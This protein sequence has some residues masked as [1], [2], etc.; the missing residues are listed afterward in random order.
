MIE[1]FVF[2][3]NKVAAG[4]SADGSFI[5][6][7]P[8]PYGDKSFPVFHDGIAAPFPHIP[9]HVIPTQTVQF[10][11][12]AIQVVIISVDTVPCGKLPFGFCR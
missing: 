12:S 10:Q 9:A 11:S 1:M 3:K 8:T 6:P 5:E 4:R 2:G 7:C